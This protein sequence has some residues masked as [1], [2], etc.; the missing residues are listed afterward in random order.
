MIE[1]CV[2]RKDDI[3]MMEDRIVRVQGCGSR[4]E[5]RVLIINDIELEIDDW[6]LEYR[7]DYI[8]LNWRMRK[9]EVNDMEK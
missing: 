3:S 6:W 2:W 7:I 8:R 9:K 5:G 4:V 1:D